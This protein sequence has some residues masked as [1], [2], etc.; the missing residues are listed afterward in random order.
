MTESSDRERSEIQR[1]PN[2]GTRDRETIRAILDDGRVCHVSFAVDGQPFVLPMAYGRDGDRLYLHGSSESRLQRRVSAEGVP[3]CVAVTHVD[4]LV[5]S[6]SAFDHSMNYRS[7]VIFGEATPVEGTEAKRSALQTVTEHLVPGRWEEV[8]P[9]NEK[10]LSATSVLA[11][12][13]E[14]A[15]AKV[16]SGPPKDPP[17]DLD[18]PH[19]AGVI[20]FELSAGAPVPDPDLRDGVEPGPS[21]TGFAP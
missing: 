16:R 4:G 14:E 18:L 10:E 17:K 9:P 7:V 19:W 12:P 3:C 2:R 5:L 13:V 11:V 8:R 1:Y 21:V 20:P 6:R 15:S